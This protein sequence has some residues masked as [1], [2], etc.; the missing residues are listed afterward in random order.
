MVSVGIIRARRVSWTRGMRWTVQQLP[1]TPSNCSR[2]S[3][4]NAPWSPGPV[5]YN[6]QG[7]YNG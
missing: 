7:E 2:I 3:C 6:W 4:R 1:E 5:R